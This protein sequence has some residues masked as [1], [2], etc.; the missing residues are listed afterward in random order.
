MKA[1]PASGWTFKPAATSGYYI[2][3]SGTVQM[4]QTNSGLSY[5]IYNWGDGTNTTDTGCQFAF[6]QVAHEHHGPSGIGQ[7]TTADA[8]PAVSVKNGRI[9]CAWPHRVY[10]TDGRALTPGSKLPAGVYVVQTALG[11]EKVAV[12]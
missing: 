4:N 2:L 6:Y 7:A 3:T 1:Q 9:V 10:T 11:S 5:K 8:T 12:K